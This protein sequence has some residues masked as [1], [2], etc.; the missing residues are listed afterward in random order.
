MT[1]DRDF[2]N[3]MQRVLDTGHRSRPGADTPPADTWQRVIAQV[4][5]QPEEKSE[6]NATTLPASI[7]QEHPV[8]RIVRRGIGHYISLAATI[9][10]VAAVAMAGW[11]ATMQ[12]NQP[13]GRFAL[14][15]QTDEA[16]VCDVEP[17]TVDEVMEIVRNPFRYMYDR[18]DP[19]TRDQHFFFSTTE[20]DL[21]RGSLLPSHET[22]KSV[23]RVTP[24]EETFEEARQ[25][26]DRYIACMKDATHGQL[27]ALTDPMWVQ[28]FVLWNFPVFVDEQAVI[29]YLE[30]V[31]EQPVEGQYNQ[32]SAFYTRYGDVEIVA[33][34]DIERS[35]QPL[36]ATAYGDPLIAIGVV[37][38]DEN[39]EVILETG[40]TGYPHQIRAG[41][42]ATRPIIIVQQSTATGEWYVLPWLGQNS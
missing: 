5:P 16:A 41:S 13:D 32:L 3:Y 29:D 19:E 42:I 10:I 18:A 2:E 34:P 40:S 36:I 20:T 1:L 8:P 33:N 9:A 22:L 12:L 23:N 11:F 17:L 28:Q 39:G 31:I 15:G 24:S 21:V 30:D 4:H 37:V 26:A 6:M 27:W 38:T 14:F 25:V 7:T 35:A